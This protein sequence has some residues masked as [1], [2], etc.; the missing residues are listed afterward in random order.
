MY[1]SLFVGFYYRGRIILLQAFDRDF[2][3]HGLLCPQT[4][5]C[6]NHRSLSYDWRLQFNLRGRVPSLYNMCIS[7]FHAFCN[8]DYTFYVYHE[9]NFKSVHIS[10][11]SHEVTPRG[12]TYQF[13]VPAKNCYCLS[14]NLGL[15]S[16]ICNMFL[17]MFKEQH[18][19][20]RVRIEGPM[21]FEPL[22]STMS[23]HS[24]L[25]ELT[26]LDRNRCVVVLK[27]EF[28]HNFILFVN[29]ESIK[30]HLFDRHSAVKYFNEVY[31]KERCFE[32]FDLLKRN[33]CKL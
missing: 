28:C 6:A 5:F 7:S 17:K 33:G 10:K 3:H 8:F 19:S 11:M 21:L 30:L 16:L 22:M 2:H 24:Q 20:Y 15:A 14:I 32:V 27:N 4:G 9:C 12:C 25:F 31:Y 18:K 29:C 23:F 26:W 1:S 13:P